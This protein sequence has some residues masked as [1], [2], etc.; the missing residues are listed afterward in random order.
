MIKKYIIKDGKKMRYGYTTGSCAAAASKAAL[1]ALIHG[2]PL[3]VV[4][5]DTP[6]G[7][8]IDIPV[9]WTKRNGQQVTCCVVKD[10]GDDPDVTHGLE[11]H[12][13]VCLNQHSLGK[14]S[15]DQVII[16]GGVG[17]GRV[18]KKGLRIG[19][20]QAAINPVPLKMITDEV[21][22]LGPT[23]QVK[24][25]ISVPKGEAVG[26]KTFNPKLGIVGGISI[27][28]TSGIVEP[29]SE[30]AF[31]KSLEVEMSVKLS[32]GKESMVYVFGNF[33]RDYINT[34]KAYN[35]DGQ[36]MQKT[37][38]FVAYMLEA[39]VRLGVKKLVYVGH[40]GKM[41]KV[42][43]GMPNTHSKYGDNRMTSIVN[44]SRKYDLDEASKSRLLECNTTDE[45]VEVLSELG[46]KDE[47]LA[48]IVDQCKE[49]CE[50]ITNYK[51]AVECLMFSNIHGELASTNQAIPWLLAI[52]ES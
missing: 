33:G 14:T 6:K 5:I 52:G 8:V 34:S 30:D 51:V 31:K 23:G 3:D 15:I 13:T 44:C 26:A 10:G 17:V 38:N 20:G 28:G 43:A 11:I 4:T 21:L 39:A 29:M 16:E 35:I 9:K 47:V 32:D 7:W 40:I 37:S 25:L 1:Y 49:R 2:T 24:V 46:I 19:V 45:A 41:V 12:S 36:Q 42:A 18:T 50:Q 27:L 48:E 22:S